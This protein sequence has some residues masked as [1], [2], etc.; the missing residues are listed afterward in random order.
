MQKPIHFRR[1]HVCGCLNE[2]SDGKVDRCE[3][4]GKYLC[5]FIYFDDRLMSTPADN[6]EK[7]MQLT[8]D[9]QPIHGLTV[10]WDS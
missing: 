2:K 5:Q 6:H 4:C 9:C 1:C 3:N 8:G 7:P 10:Y